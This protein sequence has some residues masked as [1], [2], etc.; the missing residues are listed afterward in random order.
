VTSD[1]ATKFEAGKRIDSSA[2][3]GL[4][5]SIVDYAIYI[6]SLDGRVVSWNAGAERIKGYSAEEIIGEHFS[7][8]YMPDE[9]EK[10]VPRHALKLAREAGRFSA[11]GWRVRKDG[12][13]FWA[14][15]VIDPI[16]RD[17]SI[18]GFAKITRDITENRKAAIAALEAERRFRILVQGVTDYAIYMLNPE[19]IVTNWNTGAQR[20]KGYAEAEI[21]GQHFS[22]FYTAEDVAEK[23]PWSALDIA[24]REGRYHAEG[25]RQRKDGSRFWANVVIDAIYDDDGNLLGFAKITRDLTERRE[26]E[27]ELARSREQLFQS[28]KMEAVGQ[29]TGG[30]AHDFNNLLAGITGSFELIR[31]RVA[32]GRISELERY[33]TAGLGAA[34]RAAA[35]THRLLAFSRRQ[36]LQPVLVN[37]NKLIAGIEDLVRR[38]VGPAITVEAVSTVGLW[39]CLCDA[40]QLENA[41]LNLCINARDAMP[42]GGRLTIETA[43]AWVDDAGARTRDMPPG[44]YV[45]IC[46]TDTGTGMP[47]NVVARAFDPFFT[48]KPIGMGTGLG[49]SMN[50]GFAQQS[51]GQVRI[52]SEVGEG[53]TVKIY[54]PRHFGKEK[55]EIA[56]QQ[57][58]EMPRAQ[59]GEIVLVVD[60]EPTI[61]MLITDTLAELGY[62]AIEAGDAASG[63]KVLQSDARVDLVISDVG[64]P[65]GMN[66]RQMVD[67]A[68]TRR[69]DLKVLFITGYADNAAIG[70]GHLEPGMHVLT[71]PFVMEN[72]AARIKAVMAGDR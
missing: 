61:R 10:G 42:D 41:I 30:L 56:S 17:G 27:M 59:Y 46:V 2:Y 71:K 11:E 52:Y 9:V 50:Y 65:G 39:S 57:S 63:L 47:P 26:T 31:A 60:D 67:A 6:L 23:L 20:I 49:L 38:T 51:G 8:F 22:R 32:Q 1:F 7:R 33:V 53:T 48:T 64:L 44:Q 12:S 66:G 40:N 69:S 21:V 5:Q 16:R 43:N 55:G 62:R 72:L 54:L 37:A 36:T 15:V 28:Q 58:Q 4:V 68:R 13:R 70:N 14:S 34:T 25:W 18:V 19:G 29:L 24:R 35:L 45:A 3:E